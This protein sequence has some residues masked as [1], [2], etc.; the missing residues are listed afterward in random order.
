MPTL[1]DAPV[2]TISEEG[3]EYTVLFLVELEGLWTQ[4]EGVFLGS[5]R[6]PKHGRRG[7]LP[8]SPWAVP[9]LQTLSIRSC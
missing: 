1:L 4:R 7:D 3:V 2:A 6:P 8:F 5:S 9:L